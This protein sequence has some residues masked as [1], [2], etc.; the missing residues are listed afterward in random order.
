MK[1]TP[2]QQKIKE[3]TQELTILQKQEEIERSGIK[4]KEEVARIKEELKKLKK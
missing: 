1:Q 2:L 4:H 3:K